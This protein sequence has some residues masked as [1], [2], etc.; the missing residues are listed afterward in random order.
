VLSN[1]AREDLTGLAPCNH[2]EV[3]GRVMLHVADVVSQG[4]TKV[5]VRTLDTDVLVL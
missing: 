5:A 3:D 4:C 2:E 1:Y